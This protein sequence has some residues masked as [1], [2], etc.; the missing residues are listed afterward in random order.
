MFRRQC[1]GP[2]SSSPDAKEKREKGMKVG[3]KTFKVHLDGYNMTDA[4]AGSTPSPPKEFFHFNDEGS[5]MV[6][7]YD[8]WK[9]VFAEQCTCK[10]YHWKRFLLQL[11]EPP[12]LHQVDNL[13]YRLSPRGLFGR[14]AAHLP[15]RSCRRR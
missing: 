10:I 15:D 11:D 1:S 3:R 5:R 14:D 8:Q 4:L 2:A 12:H 13:W 9:L 7:R 6:L